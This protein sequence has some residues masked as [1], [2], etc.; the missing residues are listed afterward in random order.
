MAVSVDLKK[1]NLRKKG[2]IGFSWTTFFFN[3]FVPIFRGDF[4]SAGIL[5]AID[6]FAVPFMAFMIAGDGGKPPHG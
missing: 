1:G 4:K 6:M 3:F 2:F 5:F